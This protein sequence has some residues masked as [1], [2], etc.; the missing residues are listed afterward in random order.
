MKTVF[1]DI[2][3]QLDFV[4]PAGA[5][6]AHGAERVLPAVARLNQHAAAHGIALISTMDAHAENDAEFAR[7]PPHC[8]SGT[9]GQR[10]PPATL[11]EPRVIVSDCDGLPDIAGAAQIVVGKQSVDVF[12]TRTIGP[13]LERLQADRFVVYG[14]VTEVCVRH[15]VRGLLRFAKPVTIV[16]DA[17]QSL[18]PA[19]GERALEEMR[20]AGAT[21]APAGAFL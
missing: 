2:D 19:D 7:W 15:A 4:S 11:V 14:V 9:L 17:I 18:D 12:E 8:V 3:T 6:Y 13:L 21:L 1:F 5:L 20:A 16:T 10:K